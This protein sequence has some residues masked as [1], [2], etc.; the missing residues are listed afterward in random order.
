MRRAPALA[1]VLASVLLLAVAGDARGGPWTPEAGHGYA[2]VWAKWLPGFTYHTGDGR[3]EPYGGYHEL[4]FT[5]YGELG[6]YDG[7]ALIAHVPLLNLFT[8]EDARTGSTSAHVATG[9]PTAALRVRVLRT[10]GFVMSCEGSVRAPL[11]PSQPR[12]TV[13]GTEPGNPVLGA[14]RIG[15]GVWDFGA[16]LSLGYGGSRAYAAAS[17]GYV[18]RTGGYDGVVVWTAEG[19]VQISERFAARV[20]LTRWHS[21]LDGSAPRSES[22]S[23]IGNGTSYLGFA[24]EADRRVGE[25]WFVGGSVEGGLGFLRRQTGGPVFSAYAAV[26]F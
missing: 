20:R 3:A 17:A 14:L 2:K 24:L 22:P 7:L 5:A 19:G 11:A 6:L 9:D 21:T 18:Y 4:F 16:M 26:K 15:N 1:P 12:Q 13:F 23:G 8:L 25:R 10:A